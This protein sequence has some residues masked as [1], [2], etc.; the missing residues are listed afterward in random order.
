VIKILPPTA[1]ALP[2]RIERINDLDAINVFSVLVADLQLN[3]KT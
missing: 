3:A 1:S 2:D